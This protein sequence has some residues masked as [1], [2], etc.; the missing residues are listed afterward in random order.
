MIHVDV[1]VVISNY[2]EQNNESVSETVPAIVEGTQ[3]FD[4]CFTDDSSRSSVQCLDVSLN[5]CDQFVFYPVSK[6]WQIDR[7][8]LFNIAPV[9]CREPNAPRRCTVS[10]EPV[11]K[12]VKI[13][14]AQFNLSVCFF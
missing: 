10:E 9:L 2:F 8:Q 5:Q 13:I 1:Q 4:A 14:G 11:S 3:A 7:A 6:D 12:P